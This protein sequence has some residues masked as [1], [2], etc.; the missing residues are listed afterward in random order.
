MLLIAG[1][2]IRFIRNFHTFKNPSNHF[3]QKRKIYYVI[4]YVL[5]R[6]SKVKSLTALKVLLCAF[7]YFS[8][9]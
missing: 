7:I 2:L 1:W 6:F 9:R 4:N 3:S 5:S 8:L